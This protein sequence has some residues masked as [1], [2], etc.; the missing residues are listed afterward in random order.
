MKTRSPRLLRLARNKG[1]A[2][3]I[4][5]AFVVL[6]TGVVLAY[7]S[8]TTTDRQLA[9]SSFNDTDADLLA[10]SALDIVVGDFR[11]EIVIGSTNINPGGTAFYSPAPKANVL[12]KRSGNPVIPGGVETNDPIPNLIRRSV[13]P[14][15]MPAPGIPSRAS[16]ANSAIDVSANGRLISLARW[17]SHYLIPRANLSDP[18][19]DS[20]PVSTFVAP[21][22]VIVTR[23]G[24]TPFPA[25]NSALADPTST[26]TTYAV[27]RYA[28]AVY[29][30]GGLLDINVAGY[31]SPAPSPTPW[32]TDVGRKG[33]LAFADLTALPTTPGS[34]M[35][36]T[37]INR[38]VG[39][40]NYAT[41]TLPQL[42]PWVAP[43]GSGLSF[44]FDAN[45]AANFTS[46]FLGPVG[47]SPSDRFGTTQDFG[48][49]NPIKTGSGAS[50]RTDQ[51]FI[52]RRELIALRSAAPAVANPNALQ[53]LGT[54][55]REKN[56]STWRFNGA[57]TASIEAVLAPPPTGEGRW[58]VGKLY[59]EAL[60]PGDPGMQ[61]PNDFGLRWQKHTS[62]SSPPGHWVLRG[63]SNGNAL[64]HIPAFNGPPNRFFQLLEYPRYGIADGTDTTAQFLATLSIGASLIDQY[65]NATLADPAHGGPWS[66]TTTIETGLGY[67]YGLEKADPTYVPTFLASQVAGPGPVPSPAPNPIV[68]DR[69]MRGVGDFCYG[70]R[71]NIAGWPTLDFYTGNN[72]DVPILDMFTFNSAP[73]R[74]GIV[75]L[76][77]RQ[78]PVLAALLTGTLTNESTSPTAAIAR[79][80]ATT[81]AI[82]AA[83]TIVNAAAAAPALSR[84]D[85][86]RLASAVTTPPFDA[87]ATEEIREAIPRALAEVVQTR[88]WGLL[89]DIVAQSGHYPPNAASG[90]NL[91]NPLANF[92]VDGE[93]RYWLHIAIDRFDGSIVGQQLEEVIE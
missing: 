1:A 79:G 83:N 41:V 22:W 73:I 32:V 52:T 35:L 82:A 13:S 60:V 74:S 59:T 4:V 78:P 53:Y 27:G 49:V 48:A 2:L 6:L 85:I 72:A 19:D 7:F 80:D 16:A 17:N 38:F 89:I 45:K 81:G 25:W 39:F 87:S 61:G 57:T 40:R 63:P 8:R 29:D 37:D 36:P 43:N 88:T 77:T 67:S 15:A 9:Q 34:F 56:A 18:S 31:P 44:S 54:F 55:S 5:L 62:P 92:V 23:D 24:P 91:T 21:D 14:E 64:S 47:A 11:Q 12:P 86:V 30:E 46:Y 42:S 66:T 69:Q 28:Y 76:N 51:N 26:N 3:I 70:I 58:F 71:T 75:S 33:V 20:T 90:P 10:R 84:A 50:S 68:L 65:D 93:K